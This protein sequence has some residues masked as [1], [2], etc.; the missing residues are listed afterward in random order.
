MDKVCV[1]G[2]KADE[3]A[4]FNVSGCLAVSKSGRGNCKCNCSQSDVYE[5]IVYSLETDLIQARRVAEER[6]EIIKNLSIALHFYAEKNNWSGALDDVFA[7][8]PGY[9]RAQNVLI[10]TDEKWQKVF[11]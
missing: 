1:C 2:H 5:Q 4:L 3:H 11:K 10:E 9:K 8:E 7:S 6:Q